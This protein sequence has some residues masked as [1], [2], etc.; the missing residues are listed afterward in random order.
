L[1]NA[2]GHAGIKQ[3][4]LLISGAFVALNENFPDFDA[5]QYLAQLLLHAFAGTENRYAD[6]FF[7][8]FDP[9]KWQAS[10]LLKNTN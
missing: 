6:D 7:R 8:Q 1:R 2:R 3:F 4:W 9:T 5:F 10:R